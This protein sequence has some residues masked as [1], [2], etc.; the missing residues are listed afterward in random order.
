MEAVSWLAGAEDAHADGHVARV[1]L[2]SLVWSGG[3]H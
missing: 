1:E 3:K 2:R